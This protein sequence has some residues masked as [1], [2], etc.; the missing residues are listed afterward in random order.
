MT[1]NWRKRKGAVSYAAVSKR[2][3]VSYRKKKPFYSR[4]TAWSQEPDEMK[5]MSRAQDVTIGVDQSLHCTPSISQPLRN[6]SGG[7][8]ANKRIGN[9]VHPKGIR[10]RGAFRNDAD[11]AKTMMV[12]V[13]YFYNRRVANAAFTQTTPLFLKEGTPTSLDGLQFE[14]LYLPLN[15]QH[16]DILSDSSFKVG[17][18]S[19]EGDN[20]KLYSKYIKLKGIARYDDNVGANINEGN[21][22][23]ISITYPADATP[24]QNTKVDVKFDS[25]VY[26]TE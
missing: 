10:V 11:N 12:R 13:I 25:T 1:N 3:K 8:A 23:M 26:Y 15:N 22:Q 21:I 14:A 5:R 4:T 19:D 20:I 17:T 2:R 24:N 7:S 16:F 18:S 6:I 9:Q